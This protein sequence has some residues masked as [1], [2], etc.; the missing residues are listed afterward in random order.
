MV[1]PADCPPDNTYKY[2]IL[3]F[4]TLGAGSLPHALCP[5]ESAAPR[6]S[7]YTRP[8]AAHRRTCHLPERNSQSF[9]IRLAILP[10]LVAVRFS[11]SGFSWVGLMTPVTP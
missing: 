4:P 5:A 8:T 10:I 3:S 11:G 2:F 6:L 9:H 1:A 7:P